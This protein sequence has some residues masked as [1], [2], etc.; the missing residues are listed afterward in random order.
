MLVGPTISPRWIVRASWICSS[1]PDPLMRT[2]IFQMT[3]GIDPERNAQ[4]MVQAIHTAKARGADMLFTPEMAGQLDRDRPRAA[5]ALAP[6]SENIVLAQ[7]REAAAAA[8]LW[9]HI[10]SLGLKDEGGKRW[11]NRSFIIDGAG[12]IRA[13]YDK[14]HLF[15]VDRSEEHTSELQSL[16]RISY[17]VFC[18][19]KKKIHDTRI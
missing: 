9:V 8:G 15:D 11:R 7:V 3:S 14:M 6:E 13:R 2:A 17:A 1:S 19:K 16:M 18:L 4:A 5:T 10:G 12:A